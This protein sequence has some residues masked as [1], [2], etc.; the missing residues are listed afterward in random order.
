MSLKKKLM[1][2]SNKV[3]QKVRDINNSIGKCTVENREL[4]KEELEMLMNFDHPRNTSPAA[5]A[6]SKHFQKMYPNSLNDKVDNF[7]DWY[8]V[9]MVK[10][11][12]TDIGEFHR[13]KEM[14]DFIEKMA[15]WYELRYPDYELKRILPCGGESCYKVNEIMFKEN[16]Y[17]SNLFD[18]NSDVNFIDWDEFYNTKTFI[19]SLPFEESF[20]LTKP[21]YDVC[22]SINE[23]SVLYLST[24]GVVTNAKDVE[25]DTNG[26][27]TN[28]DLIGLHI[29][30][31]IK[32]LKKKGIELPE[33]NKLTDAIDLYNKRVYQK[34]EMLN[35]V[36]YRI[37]ERGGNRIGPRR[38][39][40]FAKE[41]NRN[42]DIPMMY[43]IDYSDPYLRHFVNEY[44]KA[45]GSKKLECYVGYHSRKKDNEKLKTVIL[46]EI[47]GF[48]YN[49]TD[50]EQQLHQSLA[51]LLS[52]QIDYD[53]LDKEKVKTLR[54]ERKIEKSKNIKNTD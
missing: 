15:V 41:F 7:I 4:T 5:E 6:M 52:S 19:N 34:E 40:L 38:A 30:D 25:K 27:V 36:M 49:Y 18:E 32:F 28:E 44:I 3:T 47:F 16:P 22:V 37:I 21:W 45:G 51:N 43:G 42:I 33:K 12:Y 1:Q 8:S 11:N 14:R 2:L 31:V 24:K 53:K 17:V 13:P 54:L 48:K 10:G 50:E 26:I 9:N 20:Y 23:N 39:F 35:C 29:K 46:E